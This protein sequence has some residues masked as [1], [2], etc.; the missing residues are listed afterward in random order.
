[1]SVLASLQGTGQLTQVPWGL[2]L[3]RQGPH[4]ILGRYGRPRANQLG[5][6]VARKLFLPLLSSVLDILRELVL[7]PGFCTKPIL[8][9][10][11][12]CLVLEQSPSCVPHSKLSLANGNLLS[13]VP[14]G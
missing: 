7:G 1:M 5:L 4:G 13:Q 9:P 10:C 8:G 6:N 3:G 14:Q 11:P 12:Q 2:G